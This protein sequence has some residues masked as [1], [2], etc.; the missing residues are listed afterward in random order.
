[1]LQALELI[2]DQDVHLCADAEALQTTIQACEKAIDALSH[3]KH[4][5]DS[6]G[7]DGGSYQDRAFSAGQKFAA[8]GGK[9]FVDETGMM[10]EELDRG[11]EAGDYVSFLKNM[12]QELVNNDMPEDEAFEN[13]LSHPF[14]ETYGEYLRVKGAAGIYTAAT[15]HIQLAEKMGAYHEVDMN[16]LQNW[17]YSE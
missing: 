7:E 17:K 5:V 10:Q 15:T 14:E 9:M 8:G 2:E 3:D 4:E 12:A 13:V 6:P 16:D 1:L 11:D